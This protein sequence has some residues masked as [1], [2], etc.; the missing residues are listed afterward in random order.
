[1][2]IKTR[3]KYWIKELMF[4]RTY[5]SPFKPLKLKWY[6]GKTVKGVPYFLP[7]KWVKCTNENIIKE[8]TKSL[9]DSKLVKKTF[10]DWCDYYKGYSKAVS[11]KIGFSSCSLGWKTKWTDTDFRHEYNPVWSFVCFGY[12]IAITFYSPYDSHYFEPFLF[13]YY[14]TDRTKSRQERV[15]E[16]REKFSCTWNKYS[17]DKKETINYYDLILK[18]K[19]VQN[20]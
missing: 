5:N 16:C 19:Y 7:R 11:L 3:F 4:L 1:M 9:N 14:A 18:K 15:K 10:D 8:A 6:I 12:Q 20:N 13:Y 17:G 2:N